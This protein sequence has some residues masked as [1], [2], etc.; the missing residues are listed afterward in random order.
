[1][2]QRM[3]DL[4]G[5]GKYP[6]EEESSSG[7]STTIEDSV[8]KIRNKQTNS[9][10]E[11]QEDFDIL[12]EEVEDSM[13]DS[14]EREGNSDS[15]FAD[16]EDGNTD[17]DQETEESVN[18]KKEAVPVK[19]EADGDGVGQAGYPTER[20]P[21]I[22]QEQV[23][24][25]AEAD[26]DG[27][28]QAG[29]PTERKPNIKQEQGLIPEVNPYNADECSNVVIKEEI[30]LGEDYL[31]KEPGSQGP[32]IKDEDSSMESQPE[33]GP[34]DGR[35][36]EGGANCENDNNTNW[37]PMQEI[38]VMAHRANGPEVV[39]ALIVPQGPAAGSRWHKLC[40]CEGRELCV[41]HFLKYRKRKWVAVDVVETD[42]TANPGPAPQRNRGPAP[43]TQG[44]P[45]HPP[46]PTNAEPGPS[47]TANRGP[48]PNTTRDE[49]PK[50]SEVEVHLTQQTKINPGPSCNTND[51]PVMQ[52]V[53]V[54]DPQIS[55]RLTQT[56]RVG[57]VPPN[58]GAEAPQIYV[59]VTQRIRMEP[60]GRGPQGPGGQA[61]QNAEAEAH[62]A[63]PT[64]NAA[65]A[66]R[67][68]NRTRRLCPSCHFP[69]PEYGKPGNQ[70]KDN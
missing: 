55:V 57:H 5:K 45:V 61:P 58:A 69:L 65:R 28:G 34:N 13:A 23:P 15:E 2:V 36:I 11:G 41:H 29:Y 1:M 12:E 3:L 38:T 17:G 44:G 31:E 30:D 42:S 8:K 20:K 7:P 62:A 27:V 70:K 48:V 67:A 56:L 52:R 60:G 49:A 59:R 33:N 35:G 68:A 63:Q 51:G 10:P 50:I 25:K 24:V 18:V 9:S 47:G 6:F 43:Q 4:Y 53:R 39:G 32:A 21:N 22:K 66:T 26:G 40:D 64:D 54:E 19:A 14:T 46:Q 37:I 16:D